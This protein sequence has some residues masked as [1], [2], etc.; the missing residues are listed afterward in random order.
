MTGWPRLGD[1]STMDSKRH[2]TF[3]VLAMSQTIHRIVPCLQTV[4]ETIVCLYAVFEQIRAS[5]AEQRELYKGDT[6]LKAS[7]HG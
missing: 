4:S 7:R 6:R 3:T 1:D 2:L 5:T